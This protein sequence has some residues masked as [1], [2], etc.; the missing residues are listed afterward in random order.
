MKK[1]TTIHR[2][3]RMLGCASAVAMTAGL[4]QASTNYFDFDS[5][6][7]TLPP[8]FL[9][10][11]STGDSTTNASGESINLRDFAGLWI[12]TDGSTLE[13]GVVDQSTNGYWVVTQTTPTSFYPEKH[14]MRSQLYFLDEMEPGYGEAFTFSCDVRIGGGSATPA[15]G[16]SLSYMR[17]GDSTTVSSITEQGTSS[18]LVVSL[19]AY[20]SDSVT[21]IPGLQIKVD[22]VVKTNVS[23]ATKNGSCD[24]T[25]SIQTGPTSSD[26]ALSRADL[27]A[28]LCWQPFFVKVDTD[29]LLSVA[30]KGVTLL[31]NS[32]VGF[33]PS[34]GRFVL[35]G[36]TGGAW[37]E[38]DVD[39]LTIIT[40]PTTEPG[41]GGASGDR[42]G[43]S[44]PIYD[45]G[46]A[47]PD[48]NSF[49]VTVDGSPV[50]PSI[51]QSGNPGAGDGTGKTVV[52]Y[53]SDDQ[54]YVSGTTHTIALSFQAGSSTVTKTRSFA[55]PFTKGTLD[56]VQG[57][58]G[59]FNNHA[60]FGVNGS[61]HTGEPG[62][63][64][65]EIGKGA[66]TD[67][68]LVNATGLT[69]K[70]SG[71]PDAL[72]LAGQGDVMSVS[73]WIYQ[74]TLRSSTFWM[75]SDQDTQNQK[76][77][78]QM[79]CP[80]YDER[81]FFDTGAA[82]TG[83]RF[84]P[85]NMT[86]ATFPGYTNG[87]SSVPGFTDAT[88][89]SSWH[90]IVAVKNGE[91]KQW[92]IDGYL[93]AQQDSGSPPL[94]TDMS[95][96]YMGCTVANTGNPQA[97]VDGWIDDFAIYTN[98][99]TGQDVTNL[100]TGTAPNGISAASSLI[101]WW[102]FNDAPAVTS[103]TKV[104]PDKV[105]VTF[106]QILQVRTNLTSGSWADMINAT[107]PYT[108]DMSANPQMFFRARE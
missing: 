75:W 25:T 42:F 72:S 18:G 37:Q 92:W 91:T 3:L 22:G 106:K 26:P 77:G 6:P 7:Y 50:T 30:Y 56:R 36:R 43:W 99:L 32:D 41:V 11:S 39:N 107:S 100:F 104:A 62:D 101:A 12:S 69:N 71:F 33:G 74:R 14:G 17:A 108:N 59:Q 82:N 34:A 15:D 80:Y 40:T 89:W 88:W 55:V 68:V 23:L 81:M 1:T 84:F 31:T 64:A 83:A 102:D 48:I 87:V 103:V 76:R 65:V 24:D 79:H 70:S 57:Y 13:P 86:A 105:A 8:P 54:L 78:W 73:F 51:T 28:N 35:A 19:M 38:Q 97:S 58:F 52:S 49:S 95:R 94:Y 47:T 20:P 29:G 67:C 60:T 44:I 16:L 61:G 98:A 45:S 53:T 9:Y 2:L 4:A 5:D 27:L 66:T 46:P 63:Y 93:F 85:G 10:F 96:L 90:H 21:G